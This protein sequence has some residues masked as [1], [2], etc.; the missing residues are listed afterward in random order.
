MAKNDPLKET[1]KG[2]AKPAERVVISELPKDEQDELLAT[3]ESISIS[4]NY[5]PPSYLREYEKIVPGAAEKILAHSMEIE[6]NLTAA[7]IADRRSAG[8]TQ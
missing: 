3:I 5:P 8:G 4:S 1:E 7:E 2:I 6:K